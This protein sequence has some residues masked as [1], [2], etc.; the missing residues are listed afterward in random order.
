MF[1]GLLLIGCLLMRKSD[2]DPGCC[3]K[4]QV[5]DEIFEH[6]GSHEKHQMEKFGCVDNCVYTKEGS[7]KQFCFADG[8][9]E[10]ECLEGKHKHST[11]LRI[12]VKCHNQ[13]NV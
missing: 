12:Y 9:F 8:E 6:I 7:D 4:K 3:P 13:K 2:S 11:F 5:G 10:P 1:L